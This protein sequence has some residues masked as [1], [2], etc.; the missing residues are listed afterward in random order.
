MYNLTVAQDHTYAVG[1]EQ[2]IVHN[3]GDTG[4]PDPSKQVS[5][6]PNLY[7]GQQ[8]DP[9]ILISKGYKRIPGS[10][11]PDF[12]K[13]DPFLAYVKGLGQKASDWNY[14]M[15]TWVKKGAKSIQNHFWGTLDPDTVIR[16]YH[17]H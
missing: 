14:Y 11:V 13:S 12:Q 10:G 2:W 6:Q 4:T 8:Y 1:Y 7:E 3:C 17:H 16:F 15:E 9:D 5:G